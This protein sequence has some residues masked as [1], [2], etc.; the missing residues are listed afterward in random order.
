MTEVREPVGADDREARLTAREQA[1]DERE[2]QLAR[3][4]A[5]LDGAVAAQ[6]NLLRER[7]QEVEDIP[8]RR[9]ALAAEGNR[10][11][12]LARELE[13][14]ERRVRDA[15]QRSLVPPGRDEQIS[16]PE[17]E[18]E[19]AQRADELDRRE[20]ELAERE[21]LVDRRTA[22]IVVREL[23]TAR[24]AIGIASRETDTA[25]RATDAA[26]L[27]GA[28]ANEHPS[29]EP[30]ASTP[31]RERQAG[32]GWSIERLSRLVEQFG[33]RHPDRLAEWEAYLFFLGDYATGDEPLPATFDALVADVF[34]PLLDGAGE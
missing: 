8:R 27:T 32:D 6:K 18:Q 23:E 10:L 21:D 30:P 24:Q 7:E 29:E 13:Q 17:L 15:E 16:V 22:L 19:R 14:R 25:R 28:K 34:G 3:A 20:R 31:E 9:A 11:Q 4:T 2:H 33:S 1:L 12:E 26:Q 5:R